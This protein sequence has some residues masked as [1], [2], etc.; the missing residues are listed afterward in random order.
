M[1]FVHKLDSCYL[2]LTHL[3]WGHWSLGT[4]YTD[5]PEFAV[6]SATQQLCDSKQV[7]APLSVSVPLLVKGG[8][9][10]Q[11]A[12]CTLKCPLK[13]INMVETSVVREIGFLHP[14]TPTS[15]AA[16]CPKYCSLGNPSRPQ[17]APPATY[18]DPQPALLAPPFSFLPKLS[19]P[20]PPI[21]EAP[22]RLLSLPLQV[23]CPS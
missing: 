5:W 16:P 7:T 13:S 22:G 6:A 18:T 9:W 14:V 17:A 8:K 2:Q 21:S 23:K 15:R 11:I 10:H 1:P 12:S 20:Q 19:L 4:K 3:P